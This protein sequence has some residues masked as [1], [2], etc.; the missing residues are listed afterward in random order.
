[1][2]QNNPGQ[3]TLFLEPYADHTM[4]ET[5]DTWTT[6]VQQHPP[7]SE[8]NLQEGE[9]ANYGY[10]QYSKGCLKQQIQ[11]LQPKPHRYS[12]SSVVFVYSPQVGKSSATRHDKDIHQI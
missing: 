1:M 11:R 3:S 9:A 8:A 4:G 10:A 2:P 6:I 7:C 12:L 5:G